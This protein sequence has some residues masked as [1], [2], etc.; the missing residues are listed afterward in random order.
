MDREQF[1]D[2]LAP[3]LRDVIREDALNERIYDRTGEQSAW[4]LK[5]RLVQS[6][7]VF[8]PIS[9]L[10]IEFYCL[11][12]GI[13]ATP[14]TIVQT[15]RQL[16]DPY[17]ARRELR[18]QFKMPPR[19]PCAGSCGSPPTPT[20]PSCMPDGYVPVYVPNSAFAARGC[21]PQKK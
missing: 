16:N 3:V 14:E 11:Q 17:L 6:P 2:Y 13:K 20:P 7:R 21:D 12:A 4:H 9:I 18:P 19:P 1:I 10:E 8:R 15:L 5:N